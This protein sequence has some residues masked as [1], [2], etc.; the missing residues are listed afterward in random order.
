MIPFFDLIEELRALKGAPKVTYPYGNTDFPQTERTIKAKR[1]LHI[2]TPGVTEPDAVRFPNNILTEQIELTCDAQTVEV[3]R[4]YEVIPGF[5]EVNWTQDKS[6]QVSSSTTKQKVLTSAVVEPTAA[7]GRNISITRVN[8]VVSDSV[9]TQIDNTQNANF[10]AAFPGEGDWGLPRVLLAVGIEWDI[11]QSTGV[12]SSQGNG[13]AVGAAASLS[14]K[15]S[16]N[17]QGSASAIGDIVPIWGPE[18]PPSLPWL[19][20]TSSLPTPVSLSQMLTE[21]SV[22]YSA[23]IGSATSV[24]PWPVFATQPHTVFMTGQKASTSADADVSCAVSI[25]S[26]DTSFAVSDGSGNKSDIGPNVKSITIPDSIHAAITFTGPAFVIVQ[27]SA[28]ASAK[29]TPGQN[30]PGASDSNQA[31]LFAVASVSPNAFAATTVSAYPT[32]GIYLKSPQ[33]TLGVDGLTECRFRLCDFGILSIGITLGQP[34]ITVA[35]FNGLTGSHFKTGKAQITTVDFTSVSGSRLATGLAQVTQL[36]FA[37]FPC[38]HFVTGADGLYWLLYDFAGDA[39][40]VWYYTGTETQPTVAGATAY[41]QVTIPSSGTANAVAGNTQA[42]INAAYYPATFHAA[43]PIITT[44]TITVSTIYLAP[45][46]NSIDGNTG[47]PITTIQAGVLQNAGKSLLLASATSGTLGVWFSTG[48]ETQP[49]LSIHGVGIYVKV[50]VTPTSNAAAVTAAFASAMAAYSTIWTSG[51]SGDVVTLTS[52]SLSA[53]VAASDVNSGAA[54]TVTQTAGNVGLY[55]NIYGYQ[56]S[57]PTSIWFNTG[58]ETPPVVPGAALQ[59][60]I[61]TGNNAAQISAAVVAQIPALIGPTWAI[62][63]IT[64][65]STNS[66][67]QFTASAHKTTTNAVDV[68]SGVAISTT[69]SGQPAN[70]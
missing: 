10:Y 17:A 9:I 1:G 34:Q 31:A 16:G 62:V 49:D 6:T 64:G 14:L 41:L 36:A 18:P 52:L 59:V 42:A 32:S 60:V 4:K 24:Q 40:A 43:I 55:F 13:Q 66:A 37:G 58:T 63:Q 46:V 48:P 68:N 57:T 35:D 29:L 45:T 5:A 22:K 25:V 53:Q 2:L 21:A 20:I 50:T 7:L 23:F 69:Q 51:T 61:A 70:V 15:S 38:S 65:G 27:A 39:I 19:D 28:Y 3:Y 67:A 47:V 11:S 33:A 8:S 44:P 12:F 26:T 56:G 54:I 30:W